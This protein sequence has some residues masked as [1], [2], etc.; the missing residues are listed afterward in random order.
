MKTRLQQFA[1]ILSILSGAI[2]AT[3]YL[4][5]LFYPV[6]INV[7][8][9]EGIVYMK[10]ADISYN[11]NVLL[12]YLTNP[13]VQVLEMPNFSSSADGLHHFEQVKW[14]FHLTQAIFVLTIPILVLFFKQVI[15]KGYGPLVQKGFIWAAVLPMLIGILGLLI[16][17][18]AFFVLFHQV[19]FVGD[20]T[21]LFNP[22]TDPVI[23]ILPQEFFLHCFV[24]FFLIYEVLCLS[25]VWL[26][27]KK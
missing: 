14:L 19:L 4:A 27:R 20:S 25:F 12:N 26:T 16:G 6:E 7:L 22:A 24:L 10:A 8:N 1:V 9:L 15:Q 23:Y 2:L 5:W 18:D 13:L 21:W 11:F 3:I 17:F